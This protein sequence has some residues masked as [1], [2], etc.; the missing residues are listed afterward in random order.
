MR[1]WTIQEP[2]VYDRLKE[3]QVLHVDITLSNL[4]NMEDIGVVDNPFQKAYKW[5]SERMEKKIG[6]PAG[7]EFPW[8]A[9]YKRNMRNSKPDLREGG[10]GTP[11][12]QMVCMEL[13]IDKSRV[14]LS[15]FDLWHFCISDFWISDATSSEEW[16]KKDAWFDSLSKEEQED[17]KLKSWEQIF[18]T[19]LD[20]RSWHER[21]QW[22]QAT[23][24]ELRLEDVVKV[25]YF[26][27]R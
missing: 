19:H 5:L 20:V 4:Y 16:D 14:V 7:T 12:Q 23:F 13:E 18:D 2:Y 24:W 9:W 17:L 10:Y 22:V 6:K 15:D 11:G 27:A 1:L 21:G 26:K 8:W 3:E 25:Q